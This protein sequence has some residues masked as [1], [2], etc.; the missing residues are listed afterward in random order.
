M[1]VCGVQRS[2]EDMLH[3]R[4]VHLHQQAPPNT[5]FYHTKTV[6]G[7][8]SEGGTN[9]GKRLHVLFEEGQLA[10]SSEVNHTSAIE[11]NGENTL[12]ID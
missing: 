12:I 10:Y 2:L 4:T 3:V 7:K 6:N 8:L 1:G 9:I 5:P 11:R